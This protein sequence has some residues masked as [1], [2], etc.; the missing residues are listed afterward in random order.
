MLRK[1]GDNGLPAGWETEPRC[2]AWH[3]WLD[4]GRVVKGPPS[5]DEILFTEVD[6]VKLSNAYILRK[7]DGRIRNA[8]TGVVACHVADPWGYYFVRLRVNTHKS[9]SRAVSRVALMVCGYNIPDLIH[10]WEANHKDGNTWNN[11]IDN[12]EWTLKKDNM[13]IKN[14]PHS[15]FNARTIYLKSVATKETVAVFPRI[16]EVTAFFHRSLALSKGSN[17]ILGMYLSYDDNSE[18]P[19][20]PVK[21]P[22][23]MIT[24]GVTTFFRGVREVNK[25]LGN[26]HNYSFEKLQS[27]LA[28]TGAS[29][30]YADLNELVDEIRKFNSGEHNKLSDDFFPTLKN[31]VTLL[32]NDNT[33][34]ATI[35]C[36]SGEKLTVETMDTDEL[37]RVALIAEVINT[38]CQSILNQRRQQQCQTNQPTQLLLCA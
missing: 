34:Y 30:Q 33:R 22:V 36:Q 27:R 1:R 11:G 37:L 23:V 10:T 4:E 3:S 28:A 29:L 6:G 32:S 20:S 8:R 19:C 18:P 13:D 14:K 12:L 38:K 16:G 7:R 26:S 35:F 9:I 5:D 31:D 2:M 25:Y 24:N 21:L 17:T 15:L